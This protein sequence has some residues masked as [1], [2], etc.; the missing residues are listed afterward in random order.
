MGRVL[1]TYRNAIVFFNEFK[2]SIS[3]RKIGVLKGIADGN[4]S[5]KAQKT[6]GLEVNQVAVNSTAIL[7]GQHIPDEPALYSRGIPTIFDGTH[8]NEEEYNKLSELQSNLETTNV[9]IELL[10]Y[11]A[12]IKELYPESFKK[13]KSFIKD[14]YKKVYKTKIGDRAYLNMASILTPM[15]ICYIKGLEIPFAFKEVVEFINETIESMREHQ[16]KTQESDLFFKILTNIGDVNRDDKDSITYGMDF[17]IDK[18]KTELRISLNS[19]HSKYVIEAKRL[20]EEYFGQSM[21]ETYLKQHE[22]FIKKAKGRMRNLNGTVQCWFFD[23]KKLEEREIYFRLSEDI[24]HK[25]T[26]TFEEVV[27]VS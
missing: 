21:L 5:T 25:A 7:C 12:H 19:I 4:G 23:M 6:N 20:E 11:R 1:A 2:N 8:R 10:G 27:P 22:A 26:S 3:D 24:N 9:L 16:S 15:Y 14:Y 13:V 18:D 17:Q